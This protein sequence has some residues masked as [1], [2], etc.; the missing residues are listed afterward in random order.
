VCYLDLIWEI[1]TNRSSRRFLVSSW[2][3]SVIFLFFSDSNPCDPS[4]SLLKNPSW[5]RLRLNC[6]GTNSVMK[7]LDESLRIRV[8]SNCHWWVLLCNCWIWASYNEIDEDWWWIGVNLCLLRWFQWLKKFVR[9]LLW[10]RVGA[11]KGRIVTVLLM[12]WPKVNGSVSY[13]IADTALYRLT[14][15]LNNQWNA[16]SC[17]WTLTDSSLT[18][19]EP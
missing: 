17:V 15:G 3:D 8:N 1:R 11:W 6:E 13:C 4:S 18:D 12:S 14:C 5:S 19:F 7:I 16:D 10:W 2:T 9:V